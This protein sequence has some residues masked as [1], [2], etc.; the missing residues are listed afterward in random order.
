MLMRSIS[1]FFSPDGNRR[2]LFQ[3]SYDKKKKKKKEGEREREK[4]AEARELE[5]FS[6]SASIVSVS[7]LSVQGVCNRC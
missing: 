6:V 1:R 3:T 5:L 7:F 4:C 2:E